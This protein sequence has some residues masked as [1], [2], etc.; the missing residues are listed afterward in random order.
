M[1]GFSSR[2]GLDLITTGVG[3]Q[4]AV[5][6]RGVV[7]LDALVMG[8]VKT[9]QLSAPPGGLV[10]GDSFIVL[11][12]GTG[13]WTSKDDQVAYWT[14]A[15][16]VFI[17][18]RLGMRMWLEDELILVTVVG[19]DVWRA[20]SDTAIFGG[21]K[22]GTQTVST[23]VNTWLDV[24]WDSETTDITD[25]SVFTHST[26]SNQERIICQEAGNYLVHADLDFD[27]SGGTINWVRMDGQILVGTV[28]SPSVVTGTTSH[29]TV[30]ITDM[31]KAT[32]R[33]SAI[34]AVAAGQEIRI[35]VARQN[36]VA[37]APTIN[38]TADTRIIVEKI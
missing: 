26:S 11:S 1:S 29:C 8:S 21:Q 12:P 14:G 31:P 9:R 37:T 23:V 35:Q 2:L 18:P 16:W 32:M 30:R 22:T 6:N 4:L 17:E 38:L 27:A 28:G 36:S 19:G 5:H 3:D 13:A 33:I 7:K 34:V 15:A 20:I 10:A 25:S 24:L